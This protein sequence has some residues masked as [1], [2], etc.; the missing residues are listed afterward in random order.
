[1]KK[2][3]FFT[4]FVFSFLSMKAQSEIETDSE[5]KTKIKATASLNI[6][7]GIPMGLFQERQ[8][9]TGFGFGGNLLFEVRKPISIGLDIAWQKYDRD[10]AF[11]IEFDE[12]GD[13]F[14]TEEETSNHIFG[15]NGLIHIEPEVNFFI[16]P[17]GEGT[18][19]V[20]R[21]YT[22]TTLTDATT[23]EQFNT[24]NNNSDWSLSYGG[25]FGL[26]INV[27]QD[28]LFIDLKCAYRI[29]NT[30][31]YY[32]RIEDADFTVPLNNF[33]IESSPTNMLMPQIGVTFLLN[34]PEEYSEEEKHYEEEY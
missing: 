25:A 28:L 5:I 1:M 10:A 8:T 4:L 14:D 15:F 29:G 3:L 6:L 2:Y 22:K 19:G 27:W 26:L 18:F 17:Y 12:F 33:E 20:N 11:F 31:E 21:F 32:S 9:K 24:V 13:A 23:N 34:N 30:A 7:G 16:Q